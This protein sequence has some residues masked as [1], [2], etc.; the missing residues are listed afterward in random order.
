MAGFLQLQC[1]MRFIE[2][3]VMAVL[4]LAPSACGPRSQVP[5]DPGH[6]RP[7][8]A[9]EHNDEIQRHE[10]EA[11]AHDG[12]HPESHGG[13]PVECIDV[14]LAPPPSSGGEPLPIMRPCFATHANPA[15]EREDAA[16]VHRQA[17]A[18]HRSQ[19]ANMLRAERDACAG[20]G[21]DEISHS[22]FYHRED[23][24]AVE[25]VLDSGVVRGARVTFK[26]VKGLTVEWLEKSTRC[27]LA[28]AAVMG[29]STTFMPYC[30]LML[31]GVTAKVEES[32][33]G[34]VV[35]VRAK[36]DDMAAA[37]LGRAQDLVAREA[38]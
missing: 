32:P 37:V 17:A 31:E 25:P 21:R 12:S 2:M 19:L 20:L 34:L 16:T 5:V 35:E 8:S 6:D 22:P 3:A 18:E 13:A 27:H 28:R 10:R 14:P 15:Y 33:A 4:S 26:P 7:L 38:E 36:R 1:P 9:Q 30:P 11:R 23:I 24:A 29:F